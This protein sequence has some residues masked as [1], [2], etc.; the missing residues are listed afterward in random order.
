MKDST[1]PT[2]HTLVILVLDKSGSMNSDRD[3]VISGFNEQVQTLKQHAAD[4]GQ[5]AVSLI[6]FSDPAS[7][8]TIYAHHEASAVVELT[9]ATYRPN[10]STALFDAINQGIDLAQTHPHYQ[11]EDTAV[12]V[13][14][15]TDGQENASAKVTGAQLKARIQELEAN[16]RWT[17]TL[18]G[19]DGV[20]KTGE[21][22]ALREDNIMAMAMHTRAEKSEAFSSMSISTASYMSRRG[23][24]E[25]SSR[26]FYGDEKG[27]R[28][29]RKESPEDPPKT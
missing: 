11:D 19:P 28:V 10:G 15:F 5:T 14:A 8:E 7:I 2:K 23:A 13:L 22:L 12:L 9:D 27:R 4:A 17:V 6:T 1:S 20:Q 24:G 18:L 3:A 29:P 26:S 21:N 16:G 25:R